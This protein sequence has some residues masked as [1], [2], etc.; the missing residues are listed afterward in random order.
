MMLSEV[1]YLLCCSVIHITCHCAEVV[2]SSYVQ[3]IIVERKEYTLF[4]FH[5]A[6]I[7]QAK[8]G[9]CRST[10]AVLRK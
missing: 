3:H 9:I 10:N 5:R 8:A 6:F 2:E 1:Q 7:V 4:L